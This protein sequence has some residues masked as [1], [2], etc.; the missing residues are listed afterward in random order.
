MSKLL[1]EYIN[2]EIKKNQQVNCIGGNGISPDMAGFV[3][4]DEM[5][6]FIIYDAQ[7]KAKKKELTLKKV[8]KSYAGEPI[9]VKMLMKNPLLSDIYITKIKLVCRYVDSVLAGPTIF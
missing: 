5:N 3:S 1:F 7:T 8:R 6:E 9:I 2:E 4:V